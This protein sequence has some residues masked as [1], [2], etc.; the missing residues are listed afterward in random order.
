M[1]GA[2]IERGEV[3]GSS[4]I[5]RSQDW[6]LYRVNPGRRS[7]YRPSEQPVEQAGIEK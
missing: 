2:L 1:D 3:I 6:L 7:W 4:S 5:R